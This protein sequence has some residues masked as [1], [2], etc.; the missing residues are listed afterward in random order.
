[1]S[2]GIILMKNPKQPNLLLY[3]QYNQAL[4]WATG[5]TGREVLVGDN[6][7]KAHYKTKP[8]HVRLTLKKDPAKLRMHMFNQRQRMSDFSLTDNLAHSLRV[9]SQDPILD[10]VNKIEK[11]HKVKYQDVDAHLKEIK[12]ALDE[13]E[14]GVRPEGGYGHH[15]RSGL[16]RINT[17]LFH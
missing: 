17:E 12:G 2:S 5:P 13:Y 8:E 11:G 6:A 14:N 15:L 16:Q 10:K 1:M 3:P 7:A 9:V 4:Y